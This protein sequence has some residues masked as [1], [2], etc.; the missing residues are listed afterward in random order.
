MTADNCIY[1]LKERLIQFYI[2]P[3]KYIVAIVT[4]EPNVMLKK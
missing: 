1:V 2:L 4:D 3:E